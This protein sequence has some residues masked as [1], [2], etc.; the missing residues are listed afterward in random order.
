M[1]KMLQNLTLF[2]IDRRFSSLYGFTYKG[3]IDYPGVGK[4]YDSQVWSLVKNH[5]RLIDRMNTK[6]MTEMCLL[7]QCILMG[8]F[9]DVKPE[10]LSWKFYGKH[11]LYNREGWG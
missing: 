2:L 10:D 1:K 3:Y 7:G 5:S 11:A 6:K 4:I 9:P 8:I